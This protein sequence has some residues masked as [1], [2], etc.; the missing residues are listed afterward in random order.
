[1]KKLFTLLALLTCFIG[2]KA[3]EWEKVAEIDFSKFTGYP[4]Y[5]MDVVPEFDNGWMTDMGGNFRY[6]KAD[7]AEETSDVIVKTNDGTEYY[8]L[9]KTDGTWHQYFVMTG[10]PT[11]IDGKYKIV[12]LMRASEAVT[13]ACQMRWSWSEDPVNANVSVPEGS[14]FQ[15]VEWQ[16]EGI[17]GMSCDLIAQPNT[18]ASIEWKSIIVYQ[19]KEEGGK[20]QVWEETLANGDAEQ[21]WPAWSLE[22]TDGINANWR[23]DRAPEIC[24]WSLTMGKN[25]DDGA[26]AI[27]EAADRSRPFPTDIEEEAGKPGNHVFAVH[28][29]KIEKIDEDASIQ[30]SNQ[31]WIQSDR[32]YAK[33]ESVKIKFRYKAEKACT[34]A[35][36]WHK[37]NPSVYN[38]YTG[39]GNLDFD[40][41]WKEFSKTV[42]IDTDGTWSLAFNLTSASTVDKPQE[43][44]IFYFDDL[45]WERLV[46]DEGFFVSGI[47]LNTTKEYSNLQLDNA[48]QF[49]AE[50]EYMYVATFGTKGDKTT[51]V[52]QVMISTVRGD[53]QSFKAKTLKP[54]SNPKKSDPDEWIGFAAASNSKIDLPGLGVW[55]IYI[56]TEYN[57]LAF[58]MLEGT[59]YEEPDPVD[60]VTNKTEIVVNA[61]ERDD[62][63][64]M[65]NGQPE[66]REE[67]GGTGETWDNQFFIKANRAL[68]AEEVTVL[69]FKYKS[70]V[71]DAK[72]TTQCH[73]ETP[74][75]YMHWA[76]IGDVV[77][78]N[79]D[80]VD[81]EKEFTVPSEAN[82]MWNIAFNLAEIKSACDYSI[83]DVQ[84]YLK[85]EEEGK[86]LENLIDA[87]GT[88]NFFVKIG[89]GT[90]PYQYGTDPSGISTLKANGA[91]NA[92][93]YNL[94]GQKVG[95][96]FKGIVVKSGKKMIQK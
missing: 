59:P 3:Q 21:A 67:E 63:S 5:V 51:Y 91:N 76:A 17:G 89:A 23:T 75:A 15:E 10:I 82:G 85:Y 83:T 52:D 22:E 34:V 87:E 44:N 73:G 12:A 57:K 93:I 81:Y 2:A 11:I 58:E 39:V 49:E 47:D 1:M 29:D 42:T 64:D 60:I 88:K 25:F 8:R 70:S 16:Y 27:G 92:A 14:E 74:G 38:N 69:K 94:A 24:S 62:L 56:D 68:K 50:D 19:K 7:G 95:K 65:V 30:W 40:T 48:V 9:E 61:V 32:A 55:K 54:E 13:F 84:W 20:E 45:S 79:G 26:G 80:W 86:T 78:Q 77:F 37:K 72:T 71:A 4:H 6:V 33:G 18:A 53:A 31:Y 35:T 46:L 28:V 43:P 66:Q 36:Q 96:D 90:D 41:D